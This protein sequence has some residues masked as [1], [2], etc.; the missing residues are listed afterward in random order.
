MNTRHIQLL[1]KILSLSLVAGIL[2]LIRFFVTEQTSYLWLNWNLFLALI[3]ILFAWLV[4]LSK[5]KWLRFILILVW[6]G[7]LP[8]APYI[9]TD[10]IHLDDVGPNSM[11]W[12]DA[13]MIFTYSIAGLLAWVLSFDI[14]RNELRWKKWSIWIIGILSGFGLYLGRY[15]RFNTWDIV[16][17]PLSLLEKVGLIIIDP[18]GHDP[19][20]AMTFAFTMFLSIFY[21]LL[22]PL[23][24]NE[25]TTD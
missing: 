15:I 18:V 17:Q 12:F 10:F 7:F 11:L 2:G 19:V 1:K 23:L 20:I 9:I 25:K 8:N 21:L 5:N 22:Q 16:T 14:L 13:L 6:L 24:H 3:P 4:I